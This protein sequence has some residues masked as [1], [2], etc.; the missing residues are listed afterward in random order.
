MNTNAFTLAE[1]ECCDVIR[2]ERACCP[3]CNALYRCS[4]I[5]APVNSVPL[6]IPLDDK[7]K[8]DLSMLSNCFNCGARCGFAKI[9]HASLDNTC[10]H[11][12]DTS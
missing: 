11:T 1:T 4:L 6:P 10:C 8:R 5:A 9:Y 12:V 3:Q 2:H 7:G